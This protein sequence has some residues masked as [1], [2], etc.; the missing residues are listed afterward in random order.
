MVFGDNKITSAASYRLAFGRTLPAGNVVSPS[1][2]WSLIKY[3]IESASIVLVLI[4]GASMSDSEAMVAKPGN[5]DRKKQELG[6]GTRRFGQYRLYRVSNGL[7]YISYI[8]IRPWLGLVL[9]QPYFSSHDVGA[10]IK[11]GCYTVC[12]MPPSHRM[13]FS[14]DQV[15]P[16][17]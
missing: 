16:Q 2:N 12:N 15:S 3:G 7:V 5:P 8:L 1:D 4:S 11:R 10:A 17:A 13:L 9:N 6:L 14:L